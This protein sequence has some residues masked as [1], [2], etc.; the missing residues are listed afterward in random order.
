MLMKIKKLRYMVLLLVEEQEMNY[1]RV[2]FVIMK[3]I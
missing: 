3:R 2:N 1:M